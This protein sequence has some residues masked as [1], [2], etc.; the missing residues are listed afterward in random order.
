[1]KIELQK[2]YSDVFKSGYLLTN[3]EPRRVVCLVGLDGKKTSVSY[4]RYLL[5]C[6]IG[7]FIEPGFHVDH[8]DGNKLNDSISNLQI[9]T[10]KDNI[11]K[12]KK[13]AI[14]NR[15]I[16]P[17]C[18]K[19]FFMSKQRS[20]NKKNPCCSRVCGGKKSHLSKTK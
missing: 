14:K 18:S 20:Y 12:D 19:E 2:P 17:I 4:A 15:F 6:K 16:C 11:L 7:K 10:K 3:S 5:S 1:M 9:L 13:V 8:I